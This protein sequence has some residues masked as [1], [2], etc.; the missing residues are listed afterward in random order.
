LKDA[1]EATRHWFNQEPYA[2]LLGMKLTDIAPGSATVEMTLSEEMKNIFGAIHGGAVFSLID[3]AF[4]AAAN[5]Y[6]TV[7]V[8]LNVNVSYTSPAIPGDTLR[9]MAGEIS[10]SRR[11]S[12]YYIQVKNNNEELIATCQ[13]TAYRK[14]D[15]LPFL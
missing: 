11:I 8:A 7:A 4:E 2:K 13:A 3:G 5:S 1:L 10:K 15:P 6:G 9:A 14:K 12:T